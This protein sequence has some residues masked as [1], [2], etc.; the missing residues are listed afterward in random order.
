MVVTTSDHVGVLIVRVWH[1][2]ASLDA[3]LLARVTFRRDV[4]AETVQETAAAAGV[5]DVCELVRGWLTEFVEAA[6]IDASER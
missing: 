1:E 3:P 4:V 6:A 5:D 2:E